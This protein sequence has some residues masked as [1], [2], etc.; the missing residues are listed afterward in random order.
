V[1]RGF[2]R[3]NWFEFLNA[4]LEDDDAAASQSLTRLRRA[5]Q[6][7]GVR[8]LSDFSRTA[9]SEGRKAERQ[10]QTARAARALDA[11][12]ALDG[13]S[14][15]AV[16]SKIGFLFRQGRFGQAVGLLPDAA[17]A[18]LRT[19]EARYAFLSSLAVWGAIAFAAAGLATGIILLARF[20]PR[21]VHDLGERALPI[22]G[23]GSA[24]P[25]ALIVFA[26]PLAV[27]LGPVWILM[28]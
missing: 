8:Y 25:F 23:E 16:A 3:A 4:L 27:G 10:G 22:F 13:T 9:V 18:L 12:M 21:L 15:D 7:A 1:T 6:A 26:L 2:Y 5:A 17:G 28:W 24:T 20:G 19:R 11:A 14:Y